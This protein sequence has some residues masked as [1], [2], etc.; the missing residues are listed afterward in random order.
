MSWL[1]EP[2]LSIPGLGKIEWMD[3]NWLLE[4]FGA[5]LF[6]L[7]LLIIFVEC[8]LFFPFLPGDSLLFALGIFFAGEKIDIFPGGPG[9]ELLIGMVFFVVAAFL[10]N[11]AGY[12]L[13]RKVGPKLYERVGRILTKKYFDRTAAFFDEHGN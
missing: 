10:R 2:M 9:V 5:E 12:E 4:R 11:V 6:W 3:P 13:G 7:S 1:I 8:G